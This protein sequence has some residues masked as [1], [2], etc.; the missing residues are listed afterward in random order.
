MKSGWQ[1]NG[2]WKR[3]AIKIEFFKKGHDNFRFDRMIPSGSSW[4]M[5]VKVRR[6][7][8]KGKKIPIQELHYMMRH[9][10]KHLIYPT[11]KYL[12]IQI[13]GKLNPCEHCAKGEIRQAN[14][15][16]ISKTQQAKNPGERIFIDIT[17]MIHPSAGRKKHWLLIVDD[18]T[19]YTDS[20]FLK[21]ESD[22]VESMI[23]WIKNLFMK[24]HIRTK[25]IRL[26]NSGENR[27][28]Q[29]KTNQQYFGI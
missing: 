2:R 13:T 19:D 7:I 28:L 9:T 18:T 27:M 6:M 4:L 23:I 25:N 11:T 29:P 8:E 20:F 17:S 5:G 1:M 10:R 15:P 3:N 21:K 16:K 22:L 12:G 14:I 26:D 24:Y